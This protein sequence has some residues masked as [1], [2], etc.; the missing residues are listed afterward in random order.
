MRF[1]SA[2]RCWSRRRASALASGVTASPRVIAAVLVTGFN[3]YQTG[4]R[5]DS[6]ECRQATPARELGA[7]RSVPCRGPGGR[8]TRKRAGSQI[9][10]LACGR[11]LAG[12]IGTTL[13]DAAQRAVMRSL[14]LQARSSIHRRSSAGVCGRSVK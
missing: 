10:G 4:D 11:T 8:Q 1:S 2:F 7:Q 14:R 12:T 9:L 3:E 6:A 5:L 13:T